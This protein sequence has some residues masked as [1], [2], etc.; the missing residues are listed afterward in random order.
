MRPFKRTG[1]G[2]LAFLMT[3]LAVGTMLAESEK[4]TDY[5]S[6]SALCADRNGLVLYVAQTSTREVAAIDLET[7]KVGK[8]IPVPGTVGDLAL[9]PD[10]TRLYVALADPDGQIAVV[11]TASAQIIERIPVGHT[12]S[13]LAVSPDG[14]TL[15]VCN[16]FD[17]CVAFIDLTTGKERASI[18]VTREPVDAVLSPNGR[19]LFVANH[20]PAG[21][22]NGAFTAAEVSVIDTSS[23]N[24]IATIP[25]HNGSTGVNGLCISPD[26]RYVYATHTIGRYHMPATQLERGWVN[27]NALSIIDAL[28]LTLIT[29]VLLDN[30][31]RGA[32][33]PWGVTC[34]SDGNTLAVSH[35]GNHEVSIIDR[36]A[37]HEKLA[38]EPTENLPNDLS[39]MVGLRQRVKLTGFGPREL[40][41]VGRKLYTAEYFSDSIGLI[42]LDTQGEV[43]ATSIPLGEVL[44]RSVVRQGEF[45]FKD[46][47]WC[48]QHWQS[49]VT[50]HPSDRTDALNWDLP[51]DG[52]GTPKNTKSLVLAHQTPPTTATGVRANAETS[53]RAGAR[54]F[55]AVLPESDALAIDAYLKSL[56]PVPS[57]RLV[58]GKLS[59]AAMR[60]KALF[61]SADCS[62]CHKP[63]LYTKLKFSDVGTGVNLEQGFKYD[64]PSL[65]EAWRNGPF[66]HDGR[67]ASIRDVLTK[68]NP[69]DEHGTTSNLNPQ[70]L[71]DLIEFVESL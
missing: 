45:L 60:G 64:I 52:L 14:K 13:A 11:N 16:R 18:P 38:T 8:L 59:P 31:D 30:I 10:G 2:V 48:F 32:A 62:S 57:P 54:F 53:V 65:I 43:L 70:E 63:P 47:T 26:G 46:A 3:F 67:A 42:D 20:I 29:A 35:S 36:L 50:C 56:K 22:A 39:F 5:R 17:H 24:L 27:T 61:K 25:L 34:T 44:P 68:F 71:D 69:H 7:G 28:N 6:P 1:K 4:Q 55:R 9:S 41:A 49:C 15:Y 66:L 23:N 58:K 19:H 21:P 40:V 33:N 51:N 12:P 37:L